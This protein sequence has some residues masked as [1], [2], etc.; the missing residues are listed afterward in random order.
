VHL[1]AK[2]TRY[3]MQ[4]T[5]LNQTARSDLAATRDGLHFWRNHQPSIV[6]TALGTAI[7]PLAPEFAFKF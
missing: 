4:V 1:K 5:S 7:N 3:N 6:T 2:L